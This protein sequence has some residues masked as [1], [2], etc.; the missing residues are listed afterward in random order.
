MLGIWRPRHTNFRRPFFS[1]WSVVLSGDT[2]VNI[3]TLIDEPF[4]LLV[5][6][7]DE[8]VVVT[9]CIIAGVALN[10]PLYGLIAGIVL[11]K[12]YMK[13][14][15]GKP[16]GYIVHLFWSLGILPSPKFKAKKK[17]ITNF[18]KKK[19]PSKNCLA[20]PLIDEFTN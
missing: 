9:L 6:Q 5:W 4:H 17:G 15:D 14:R 13:T 7:F 12:Q 18:G 1:I 10:E 8:V 2:S 11:R 16:K 20:S 3:P 19:V